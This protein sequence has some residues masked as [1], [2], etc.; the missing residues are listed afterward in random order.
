[1]GLASNKQYI[2]LYV[3][4]TAESG[5]LAEAYADRLGKVSVGKSCI[6]FRKAADL[7]EKVLKALLR[8]AAR[9]YRPVIEAG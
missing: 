3:T 1:V 6:R 7:D 5:Y 8:E 4:A 9:Q 2:S